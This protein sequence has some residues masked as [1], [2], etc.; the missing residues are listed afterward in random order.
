[1]ARNDAPQPRSF[2]VNPD[3]DD[4]P[5][6]LI[7]LMGPPGGG[8]TKSALRIADG[9]SRVRGGKPAVIDTEAGRSLKHRRGP[10]NPEGH[11]FDYIPFS[12]PFVPEH[13]RD[14]IKEAEKLNPSCIIVDSAS[15]EHEG[16][17]GYLEWHDREV[18]GA[19]GNKW[20]AWAKPSASRRKL[21]AAMQHIKIPVILTFRAREKTKQQGQ[22]IVTIGYVPVAPMEIVHTL[23]LTCL[24]PPRSNGVAVW[25]SNEE[26][27]RTTLKFAGFLAHM[28]R[29]GAPLDE[30]FGEELARWQSGEARS[31]AGDNGEPRKRTPEEL[32]DAYVE[33][34]NTI[35]ELDAF[36]E[37][38]SSEKVANWIAGVK[39][40]R[41]DL[42]DRIV[43]ANS[44]RLHALTPREPEEG[45]EVRDPAPVDNEDDDDDSAF[46]GGK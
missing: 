28:I 35:E 44:R 41:P 4:V 21:I 17:G 34:I 6:L 11:D 31:M 12:P 2:R 32:V 23:D 13:F 3:E 27:E 14:A 5:S 36:R 43:T 25:Q 20:A 10:R 29:N 45:V 30:R 19:G 1:M 26:A 33:T 16:E 46:G 40:K 24:L 8:K 22:K 42:F 18:P 9:I 7:G 37:Y 39:T 15:D 38:Q